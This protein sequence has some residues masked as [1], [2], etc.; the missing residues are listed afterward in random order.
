MQ[1]LNV[2]RQRSRIGFDV[3]R[4]EKMF[5]GDTPR[6]AAARSLRIMARIYSAPRSPETVPTHFTAAAA[7]SS[8]AARMPAD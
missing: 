8:L 6:A 1:T 5:H 4:G 7:C 2:R 3:V